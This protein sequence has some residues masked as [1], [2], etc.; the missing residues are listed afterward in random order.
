MLETFTNTANGKYLTI[1]HDAVFQ[2]LKAAHVEGSIFEF[3]SHE[4]GQ[5]YVVR[6]M[7]GNVVLRDRGALTFSYLVDTLGDDVPGGVWV[8]E[9][10]VRVSGP[11]PG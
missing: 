3:V 5:P 11:H 1:L 2:D 9:P 8:S 4:V 10:E 7:D 6:D